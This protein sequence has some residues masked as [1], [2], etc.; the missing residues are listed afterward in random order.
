MSPEE[1]Q[2]AQRHGAFLIDIRP[3]EQRK[4]EGEVPGATVIGRTILE[5]RLCPSSTH[6]IPD[7]PDYD[8]TVIVLCSEG[9]ASS[10]AAAEL[11][12]LG[13]D[14]ATDVD[15]GIGAWIDAGLPVQSSAGATDEELHG[16]R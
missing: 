12:S 4:R 15:G 11:Q 10:L 3:V 14:R 5:W 16:P 8:E 7:A 9:Y 13:F 2:A 1:A 6:R